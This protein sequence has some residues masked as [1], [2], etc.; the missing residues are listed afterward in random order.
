M[1]S[2]FPSMERARGIDTAETMRALLSGPA[3]VQKAASRNAQ[4]GESKL[5]YED[6]VQ[7][8]GLEEKEKKFWLSLK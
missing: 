5:T 2:S 7:Q 3:T 4:Y 1:M 8:G 6:L